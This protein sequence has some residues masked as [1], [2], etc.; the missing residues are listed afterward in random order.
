M[1]SDGVARLVQGKSLLKVFIGGSPLSFPS[2]GMVPERQASS[3]PIPARTLARKPRRSRGVGMKTRGARRPAARATHS[4]TLFAKILGWVLDQVFTEWRS[5]HPSVRVHSRDADG[6]CFI[7][8]LFLLFHC[9]VQ[10]HTFLDVFIPALCECGLRVNPRKSQV[11]A[12]VCLQEPGRGLLASQGY[13]ALAREAQWGT[14]GRYLKKTLALYVSGNTITDQL[15]GDVRRI[16]HAKLETERSCVCAIAR[17]PPVR[18][19]LYVATAWLWVAP[20]YGAICNYD[21]VHLSSKCSV[22]LR[23]ETGHPSG[24]PQ[25]HAFW[26]LRVRRRAIVA[27]RHPHLQF[28]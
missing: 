10:V 23:T 7:D 27:F 28:S 21:A 26:V 11:I 19:A 22:H 2:K 13:H 4:P 25:S 5:A 15:L 16:V 8:D 9:W 1:V 12:P 17:K 3:G 18:P 20:P 24:L 6:W 14:F